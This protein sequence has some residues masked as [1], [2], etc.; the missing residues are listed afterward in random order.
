MLTLWKFILELFSELVFE[1]A[2]FEF[3]FESLEICLCF[4]DIWCDHA[5]VPGFS[6]LVSKNGNW[7]NRGFLDEFSE[8]FNFYLR[9]FMCVLF[10]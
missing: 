7:G 1:M 8:L 3:L 10:E 5:G 9:E 6:K 2:F 4:E